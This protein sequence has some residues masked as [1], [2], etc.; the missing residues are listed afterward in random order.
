[1]GVGLSGDGEPAPAAGGELG[2]TFGFSGHLS[3]EAELSTLII[4]E[5]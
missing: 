1:L 4:G 5:L 3:F 2:L